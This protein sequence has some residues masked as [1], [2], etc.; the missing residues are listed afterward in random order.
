MLPTIYTDVD[1]LFDTRFELLRAINNNLAMDLL[2]SG[3]YHAREKHDYGLITRDIFLP[4]WNKRTK[5]VLMSSRPTGV[6]TLIKDFYI[7]IYR[8]E[9]LADMITEIKMFVNTYPYVLSQEESKLLERIYA[10]NLPNCSII[11]IN[12]SPQELTTSWMCDNIGA[13]F[14][15]DYLEWLNQ[16]VSL[17]SFDPRINQMYVVTPYSN[18]HK[19][20]SAKLKN[21]DKSASEMDMAED[22]YKPFLNIKFAPMLFFCIDIP[23]YPD[24]LKK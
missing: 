19:P 20:D 7:D 24:N 9:N 14:M 23:V 15:Y 16:Q 17:G 8:Q 21:V 2:L 3:V 22:V 6:F 1:T 4:L 11:S 5:Q 12:K 18:M 13:V 10:N